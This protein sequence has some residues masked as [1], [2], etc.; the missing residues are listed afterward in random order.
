MHLHKSLTCG[1]VRFRDHREAVTALHN[2]AT[3][4]L[5]ADEDAVASRRRE[6]RSYECERCHGYHLTSRAA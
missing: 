3:L 2:V 4:R 5:R 1:K 6:V